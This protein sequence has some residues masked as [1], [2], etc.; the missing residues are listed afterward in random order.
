MRYFPSDI[1]KNPFYFRATMEDANPLYRVKTLRIPEG[2]IHLDDS[3]IVELYLSRNESA[4]SHTAQ[5]YGA[6]LRK[7]ADNILHNKASAEA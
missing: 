3:K 1:V 6:K 7:I 5:K 2:G 4:I